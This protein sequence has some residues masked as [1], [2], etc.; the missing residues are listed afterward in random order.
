MNKR[1]RKKAMFKGWT[2]AKRSEFRKEVIQIRNI[3]YDNVIDILIK[4]NPK[5]P[6]TD[7]GFKF[8]AKEAD[9]FMES[10]QPF[11]TWETTLGTAVYNKNNRSIF[12]PVTV[13][14]KKVVKNIKVEFNIEV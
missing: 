3:V 2:K 12:V 11:E 1:Q 14:P 10:I 8:L 7:E 9:K 4:P 5:V 6:Y 13:A